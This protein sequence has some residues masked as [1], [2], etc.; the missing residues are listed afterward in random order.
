MASNSHTVHTSNLLFLLHISVN[1][2]I[3]LL[4]FFYLTLPLSFPSSHQITELDEEQET[5]CKMYNLI[6]MY[7]V[8]TPPEDMIVFATLPSSMDLLH[9]LI[10][11]A[12]LDRESGMGKLCTSLTK[13]IKQL[14]R[15]VMETKLKSQVRG[16]P[17]LP[18]YTLTNTKMGLYIIFFLGLSNLA[19]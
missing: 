1:F 9:M 14:N 15:E 6:N 4:Y 19:R 17:L 2:P 18:I 13:A 10:D 11:E 12:E 8:P 16:K 7:S 3:H 5:V